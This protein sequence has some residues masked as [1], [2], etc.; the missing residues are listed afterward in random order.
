MSNHA[1]DS[2]LFLLFNLSARQSS[3]R[4]KVSRRLKKFGAIQLKTSTRFGIRDKAVQ[5]L[6]EMIHDAGIED[7]KFHRLEGFGGEQIFKGWAQQ[8]PADQEILSAGSD[9]FD[10]PYAL[11]KRS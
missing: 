6:A 2:W 1:P 7:D 3:A 8:G 9:C 5:R 4:A 11:F 10:G